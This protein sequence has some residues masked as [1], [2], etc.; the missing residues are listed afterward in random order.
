[1][2]RTLIFRNPRL[3]TNFFYRHYRNSSTV[4]SRITISKEEFEKDFLNKKPLLV[5]SGLNWSAITK[6][7][8]DEIKRRFP[9][10]QATLYS[11]NVNEDKGRVAE[12]PSSIHDAIKRMQ[13]G[14]PRHIKYY[15]ARQSIKE[16]FPSLLPEMP[17]VPWCH[18]PDSHDVNLWLGEEGNK[19]AIHFDSVDNFLIQVQ[20]EKKVFLFHPKEEC[21]REN[22][23]FSGG[24]LNFCQYNFIDCNHRADN[25]NPNII[26]SYSVLLKPGN[27][28]Y[29]PPRWWHQVNTVSD[30]ISVNYFFLRHKKHVDC[31]QAVLVFQA[32]SLHQAQYPREIHQLMNNCVFDNCIETAKIVLSQNFL[33]LA[34]M[35]VGIAYEEII[36]FMCQVYRE[37]SLA[38]M[39]DI[40]VIHQ[41]YRDFNISIK[42]TDLQIRNFQKLIKSVLNNEIV[43]PNEKENISDV[44][45]AIENWHEVIRQSTGISNI[46]IP[47]VFFPV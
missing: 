43:P 6:W 36:K 47:R 44:I 45:V 24:R 17:G 28:L 16:Y 10:T 7:N 33:N 5:T 31:K 2:S 35:T 19:T 46:E 41:I 8:F 9:D 11:F 12:P 14:K 4:D 27:C 29:I 30:S 18:I 23:L 34:V 13:Q 38:L 37:K 42:L 1:M 40:E 3:Y 32:V 22:T 15:I 26:E 21:L 25:S 39:S 20:G